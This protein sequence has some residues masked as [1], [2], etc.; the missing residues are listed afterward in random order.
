VFGR[1]RSALVAARVGGALDAGE[2]HGEHLGTR[3]PRCAYSRSQAPYRSAPSA[4][5][6]AVGD[7]FDGRG[8]RLRQHFHDEPQKWICELRRVGRQE[9]LGPTGTF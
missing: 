6:N 8:N 1:R 3:S 5:E 4:R 9:H 2:F 7:A